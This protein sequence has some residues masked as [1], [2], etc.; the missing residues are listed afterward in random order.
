MFQH[1][2]LLTS[3][4]VWTTFGEL[5]ILYNC[6]RTA[7]VK[8]SC[9]SSSPQHS[10]ARVLCRFPSSPSALSGSPVTDQ[11]GHTDRLQRSPGVIK[12]TNPSAVRVCVC[13]RASCCSIWYAALTG[14]AAPSPVPACQ[15]GKISSHVR[16]K[17]EP[18]QRLL[19]R[20]SNS[21]IRSQLN[22]NGIYSLT[23]PLRCSTG[24]N[25]LKLQI[26]T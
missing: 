9:F 10:W 6:T 24:L 19:G 14:G 2:K 5:A 11:D 21:G 12:L 4:S 17:L 15:E 16:N 23:P 20:L 7:S 13:E 22:Q 3:I 1:N 26:S 25:Y 8:G 18:R